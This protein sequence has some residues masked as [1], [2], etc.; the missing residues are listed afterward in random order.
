MHIKEQWN[1]LDSTTQQWLMDNPGCMVLPRTLTSIFNKETSENA[2]IN[3]HGESVLT[4]EDR[5]FIRSKA[6]EAAAA[7]P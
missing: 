3:S 7:R 5:E 6:R 2:E 1:L 4:A